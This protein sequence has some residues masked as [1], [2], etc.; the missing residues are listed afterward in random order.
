MYLSEAHTGGIQYPRLRSL[1][2]LSQVIHIMYLFE[3]PQQNAYIYRKTVSSMHYTMSP[4]QDACA[5][6]YIIS[7]CLAHFREMNTPEYRFWEDVQP[8]RG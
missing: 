3:A 1:R 8:R 5:G 4:R 7:E 2:S 6:G